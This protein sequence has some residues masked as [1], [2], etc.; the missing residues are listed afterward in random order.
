MAK[1]EIKDSVAII[2]EGTTMIEEEAFSECTSLKCVTLLSHTKLG[3]DVF[4]YSSRRIIN[5]PSDCVDYYKEVLPE[6]FHDTIVDF[7]PEN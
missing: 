4:S 1:F 5:V 6:E 7:D 3:N 2:P